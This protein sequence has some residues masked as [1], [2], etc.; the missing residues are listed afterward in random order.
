VRPCF[1]R[2]QWFTIIA[3]TW[4]PEAPSV[5]LLNSQVINLAR[6]SLQASPEKARFLLCGNPC[7][8]AG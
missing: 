4:E 6:P 7:A 5:E 2:N 8:S 3:L 1:F